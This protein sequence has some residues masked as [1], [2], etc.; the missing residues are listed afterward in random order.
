MGKSGHIGGKIAATLAST[1]TN[2]FFVHPAEMSHG[3][4]GMLRKDVTL[5]AISNSGESR[6]LRD[7]LIYCQREGIPVIGLTQRPASF[8]GRSSAVCL[9][10]PQVAEACPNGLAPTTSTL[11]T[12][13]LG[14]ALAMVLMDRRGFTAEAFGLHHPGGKLGMSLQS[15]RDWMGDRPPAP[16]TI[17]LTATFAEVVSAITEGRKGAAA[18]LNDDGTLAGIITDG[19]VRRAFS[20]DLTGLTAA[21]IMSPDP[22]IIAPDARM[23]DAVDL[24]TQNR[25]ATLLVVE[26]NR[27]VA[28]V[29]IAE[30][31]QAGYVG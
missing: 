8:L 28:I 6:E 2:A 17:P 9:T 4:L 22:R 24:M 5:L 15:V 26:A 27:P 25:I 20:R 31:M 1:G 11:M 10:M 19:D 21:D 23:S 29:H 14:D 30:L 13:A 16:A 18:V 7:P 12:L 3:D